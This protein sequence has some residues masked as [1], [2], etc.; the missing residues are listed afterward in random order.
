VR[1]DAKGI[2]SRREKFSTLRVENK[3]ASVLLLV[4]FA[5]EEGARE[6]QYEVTAACGKRAPDVLCK[7]RVDPR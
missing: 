3:N 4:P 2:C 5:A 1:D 7:E 6:L